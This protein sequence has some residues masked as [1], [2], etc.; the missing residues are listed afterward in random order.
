M[1]YSIYI[2]TYIETSAEISDPCGGVCL[3]VKGSLNP[4]VKFY[5]LLEAKIS[6]CVAIFAEKNCSKPW[7]KAGLWESALALLERADPD[8]W[9]FNEILCDTRS[10]DLVWGNPSSQDK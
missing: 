7:S 5:T 4:C 10:Q 6:R 8:A 3:W 9:T 1:S 2:C